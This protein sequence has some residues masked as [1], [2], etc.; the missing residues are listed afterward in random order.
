MPRERHAVLTRLLEWWRQADP[1]PPAFLPSYS[2]RE[3]A[4]REAHLDRYLQAVEAELRAAPGGRPEQAAAEERLAAAFRLFAREALDFEDR[5]LDL[6]LAG[7]FAQTGREFARAARLYDPSMRA[8]DIFQASRNAWTANGLQIILGLPA[9]LTPAIFGYSMLYP[10]TDN[11]LDHPG[12]SKADKRA[13][14]RR[15]GARLAGGRLAPAGRHEEQA[16]ALVGLI[17]SQYRRAEHPEVF[18]SLCAIHRAQERSIE[19]AGAGAGDVLEIVFEK[20][21]ASV[22]ADAWLAAGTLAPMA[23]EFAFAWGVALQ[24]GDDLQDVADDARDGIRTAFSEAAGREPL[25]AATNRAFH[26]GARVLADLDGIGPA[27]PPAIKELIRTSFFMLLTGAAG[28]ARQFYSAAYVRDLERRSPFTFEFLRSRRRRFARKR[29]I[30]E[31]LVGAFPAWDAPPEGILTTGTWPHCHPGAM[32]HPGP[33][34]S[35]QDPTS[36]DIGSLLVRG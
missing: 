28:E 17:E 31:R 34:L 2:A 32:R 14:N 26:F 21:G 5:H 35:A 18:A 33:V 30:L 7:G 25:D 16:W 20:G 19:L 12:V 3:Q 10:C 4:R 36:A 22:L 27:A 9:R 6:L 23:V 29:G 1:A 15:F 8:G 13:F 24:L 11:Y